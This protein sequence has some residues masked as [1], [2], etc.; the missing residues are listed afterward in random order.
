[1]SSVETRD[2]KSSVEA[3]PYLV[4]SGPVYRGYVCLACTSNRVDWVEQALD[5]KFDS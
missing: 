4:N 3:V 2:S 5:M 1:M